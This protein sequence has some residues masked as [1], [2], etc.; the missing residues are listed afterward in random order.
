MFNSE[1][2]KR[3]RKGAE[4]SAY[5]H[6]IKRNAFTID[7]EAFLIYKMEKKPLNQN[8]LFQVELCWIEIWEILYF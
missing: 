5:I 2:T 6:N 3:I 4:T 1:I 7:V 8:W